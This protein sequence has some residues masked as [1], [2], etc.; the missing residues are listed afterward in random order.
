M[1]STPSSTVPLVTSFSE[2]GPEPGLRISTR[3]AGQ[4]D[5]RVHGVGHEVERDRHR[6]LA[7]GAA[8]GHGEHGQHQGE[9]LH[10]GHDRSGAAS[11]QR[12]RATRTVSC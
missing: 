6:L 10:A 9:E 8:A 11:W 12:E 3:V 2:S 1:S 4:V 5:R 7:G